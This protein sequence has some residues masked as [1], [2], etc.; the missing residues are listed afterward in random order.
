MTAGP[1]GDGHLAVIAETPRLQLRRL[2]ADDVDALVVVYGD[3]DVVR[4]VG[5]HQPLPRA[6]CERWVDVT[7]RNYVRRGYGMFAI[8]LREGER[9]VGFCGLVHP[10]DQPEAEIKYALRQDQWGRGLA[11]E[12]ARALLAWG[13]AQCGLRRVIATAAP[14]NEASHRVLL[15]AGLRRGALRANDDGSHTQLFE[16]TAADG[17]V[18]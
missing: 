11:T 1:A 7:H 9:A 2:T 14:Q 3:S 15:K 6:D 17:T 4:W 18:P 12:A 13:A 5:D 8:D 16:W 10:G